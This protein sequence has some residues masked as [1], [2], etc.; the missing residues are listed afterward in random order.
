MDNINNIIDAQLKA[1]Q[2]GLKW[3]KTFLRGTELR[4][5]RKQLI[6]NKITLKRV[7]YASSMNPAAAVFGESQVGKSYLVDNLLASKKGPLM[8]YDGYG[9][10]YGF[11]ESINPM[12]GG[13]ESTSLVSRFTTKKQWVNDDYPIKAMLLSPIDV[14]L[15]LCDT[16][17]N[18]VQNHD[19]PDLERIQAFINELKGRYERQPKVQDYITEDEIFEMNE[20]FGMGVLNRGDIFINDLKKSRFFEE[21]AL[22]IHAVDVNDWKSVFGFLWNNNPVLNDVFDKLIDAYKALGFKNEVYIQI[23]AILRNSGTILNVDRL[24]ELFGI[25]ENANGER[26]QAAKVPDMKVWTGSQ[27]VTV[28]KSVFC[29]LAAELVLKVSEELGEE[30]KFLQYLDI[31]DFPGARSREMLDENKI[32]NDMA[33]NLLIRGKV[34]YLFNKYSQQYL[35]SNL[36]FC[37]HKEK[38]EVK[39][40]SR[41]LEGWIEGMVGKT[42]EARAEYIQKA[43][44][45][46][47]FL[48]G[49]KFNMDLAITPMD[50]VDSEEARKEAIDARWDTRFTN[51]SKLIGEQTQWFDEWT[52]GTSFD[53][54]YLLRAYD[55][56]CISG[57]FEGYQVLDDKGSWHLRVDENGALL[58]EANEG[59]EYVDFIPKLKA[60]FLK[61][62]FVKKHFSNPSKSWDEAATLNHDGSDWIIENLYKSSEFVKESREGQFDQ[63]L[64]DTLAVLCKELKSKYHD[65]N[66]DEELRKALETAGQIDLKLDFLF[67]NDKYFFSDF[68][69]A[70]LVKEDRLHDVI[71]DTIKSPKIV[72]DT[73]IQQLFAIRNRAGVDPK[74]SD[75]ENAERIRVAYHKASRKELEEYLASLN[76]T[77]QDIIHPRP[78]KNFAMIIVDEIEKV[79]FGEYLQLDRFNEFVE[80]GM[81]EKSIET[82]LA[83]MKVLYKEKLNITELMS[84]HIHPYVAAPDRL[85]DMVEMLA[86][87]CSEII[88]KFV[89]TMGTAYFYEELWEDVRATVTQNHFDVDVTAVDLSQETFDEEEVRSQLSEV[90]DVFDNVDTILNQ[91]P[92]D[93]KKLSYFSNYHAYH[94][95]TQEMKVAF[96]ATCGIPK[97]DVSMNNE[98]RNILLNCI[99]RVDDLKQVITNSMGLA[100]L[101]SLES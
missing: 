78:V 70:M 45:A 3:G 57:I 28:K 71:L 82:L 19:F 25:T 12:G 91:V 50:R 79:W 77:I 53:N 75:D 33:C 48:I 60:S 5:L 16:Y 10:P 6:T 97:Y 89:N 86:D 67:G 30:K 20:Y 58:G 93:T 101:K 72:E 4:N 32:S 36:L 76:I 66:S 31:L 39:T 87:I 62:D 69:S 35:I 34:A 56:S 84:E 68:I 42:P 8:I 85:D 100:S 51:L 73:D 41:L 63:K 96:L 24:Y 92:V 14:V 74:Q 27:A 23:D 59:K 18:D 80:R 37:H 26:I 7:R 99:V 43:K 13:K 1:N 61:W 88:N 90:F 9:K 54:I 46:P 29:A 95:W 94:Q 49:T 40:L 65:D 17:F 38:S 2:E 98:L 64:R 15:T 22:V 81:D 83:N 55:F 47:L 11:I 44:V 21:L 52:P